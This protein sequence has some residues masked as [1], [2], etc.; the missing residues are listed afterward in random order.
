[1]RLFKCNVQLGRD[2][3]A[4]SNLKEVVA[5]DLSLD[6]PEE[7]DAIY[8]DSGIQGIIT[9]YIQWLEESDSPDFIFRPNL[10]F[11]IARLYGLLGD[12]QQAM[13]S[14]EKAFAAGESTLPT[15]NNRQDLA[16]LRDNPR[17]KAML[18]EMGLGD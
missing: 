8:R 13:A 4:V 5:E 3:E 6:G 11:H 7:L 12:A 17:F 14:L 9:W 18:Y 2:R 1:M 15:I 10:N 16:F